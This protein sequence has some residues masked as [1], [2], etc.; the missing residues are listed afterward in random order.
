MQQVPDSK[1]GCGHLTDD[2]G[3]RGA[4]HAPAEGE[5]E[6]RVQDD[7]EQGPCQGG[8][9]GEFGAAIGPDDG[10]YGLTEHIKGDA[11]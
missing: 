8:D 5:N 4:H 11:Q 6:D 7:V 3:H 1:Q 9:H 10:V 2:C